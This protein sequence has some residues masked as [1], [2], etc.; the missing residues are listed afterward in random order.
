MKK[1]LRK[2][3][4]IFK[5]ILKYIV[6]IIM[7]I[8]FSICFNVK[9]KGKENL[10]IEKP[11]IITPNHISALDAIFLRV[12]IEISLIC[13]VLLESCSNLLTIGNI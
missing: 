4:N 8:I 9:I 13:T 6:L 10:K 12:F 1:V 3:S 11:Y 2:V 7:R 5:Q